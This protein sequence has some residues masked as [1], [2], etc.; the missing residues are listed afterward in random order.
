MQ[1][2]YLIVGLRITFLVLLIFLLEYLEF[3]SSYINRGIPV[4]VVNLD[5]QN[6]FNKMSHRRLLANVEQMGINGVRGSM[7][8]C[9]DGSTGDCWPR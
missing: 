8:W 5:F 1:Y 3:V 2:I 7:G 6:V 9:L 4:D